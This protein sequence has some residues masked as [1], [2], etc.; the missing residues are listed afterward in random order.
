MRTRLSNSIKFEKKDLI[1]AVIIMLKNIT[2]YY[3]RI[4][5]KMALQ[6]ELS[7]LKGILINEDIDTT[8]YE[9]LHAI[10]E[11][12]FK[13]TLD[14]VH[15][16][17]D[18]LNSFCNINGITVVLYEQVDAVEE[19]TEVEVSSAD[20]LQKKVDQIFNYLVYFKKAKNYRLYLT[21]L[22]YFTLSVLHIIYFLSQLLESGKV[23]AVSIK[24]K[25][26]RNARFWNV[27]EAQFVR[28]SHKNYNLNLLSQ[29]AITVEVYYYALELLIAGKNL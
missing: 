2:H 7:Y 1:I 26:G 9:L 5:Y 14:C 24:L 20:S 11:D 13:L 4:L 10:D 21:V 16:I 25:F 3:C 23:E 19:F 22:K 27:P 28:I 18:S 12:V 6:G 17:Y 29:L 15:K 8:A